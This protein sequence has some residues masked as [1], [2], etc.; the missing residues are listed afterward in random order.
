MEGEEIWT[1]QDGKFQPRRD[2]TQQE[3][4]NMQVRAFA[5]AIIQIVD[6]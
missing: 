6:K 3:I 5:E 1:V 2:L 4:D